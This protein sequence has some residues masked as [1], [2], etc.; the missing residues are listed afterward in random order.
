MAITPGSSDAVLNT[1][2]AIR[3]AW[4]AVDLLEWRV[5]QIEDMLKVSLK[6]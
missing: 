3:G 6:E 1:F 2:D 5:K 4:A